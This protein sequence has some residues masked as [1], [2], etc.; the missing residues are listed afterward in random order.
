MVFLIS[1]AVGHAILDTCGAD[2]FE[3]PTTPERV[4]RAMKTK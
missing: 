3:N 2:L 4:W 1:P